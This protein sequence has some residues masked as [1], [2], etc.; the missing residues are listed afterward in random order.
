M[1]DFIR[2]DLRGSH[3]EQVDLSGAQLRSVDLT[4]AVFRGVDLCRVAMRGVELVDVDIRG[5]IENLRINGVDIGPLVNAEL[6]RRHPLR[7]RMRPTNPEGFARPGRSLSDSG[8]R[9]SSGRVVCSLNCCTSRFSEDWPNLVSDFTQS[10]HDEPGNLWFE[11]SRSMENSD[12]F[13]L[14]EAFRDA[15]AGIAHVSSDHFKSAINQL[16]PMLA[17][18]PEIINVEVPGTEW[19][20]LAE[21]SGLDPA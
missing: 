2:A 11:W 3:F 6:N 19:S 8:A 20:E 10:T 18:I 13:V 16:P 12:Q 5:E 21:M 7:S 9:P 14:L 4:D 1:V 17:R 15:E